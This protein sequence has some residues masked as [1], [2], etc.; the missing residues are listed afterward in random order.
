[1]KR[2]QMNTI[3]QHTL[4]VGGIQVPLDIVVG[5]VCL[6]AKKRLEKANIHGRELDAH[7]FRRSIDARKKDSV[8]FVYSVAVTGFFSKGVIERVTRG[9]FKQIS[10]LKSGEPEVI[11]GDAPLTARPLVVGSGPAGLFCALLLA[12]AGYH[13][14][15]IERGGDVSERQAAIRRFSKEHTLD[16]ESNVQFGAGGAGTFSDGK[17]VTRV[18]D[19]LCQYV[20]KTFCDFGAPKGIMIEAKPHIGTDVLCRIVEN[21]IG[22]IVALGGEVRYH[23]KLESLVWQGDEV[24]GVRTN[25]GDI[26]VGAVV[27]AIGHSARDTYETLLKD[28]LMIEPKP[29]SVGVRV[30]HLQED[31]DRA[32]YGRFAGHPALGAAEYH[33]SHDTK[34]RGVYS[35]CM[36][37]GGY[38]MAAASEP[39]SVVVNGMS[40]HARDGRNANSAIAVSVRCEDYGGT[41]DGAIAFQRKIERAAFQ[42]GGGNY[43]V[44]L[45]TMGDFINGGQG[46]APTR[47]LPTYMDGD[48]FGLSTPQAYLPDFICDA[49]RGGLIAFENKIHGFTTPDALISGAETRTSAPVRILREAESRVAL[50]SKNLYPC[51][52]GAG[53]AGGITSAALDGIHTA[54]AIMRTYRPM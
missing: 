26:P 18:N 43:A 38:V 34:G 35:F 20:L 19:P 6:L 48:H 3:N 25:G 33:L 9:E 30:E 45:T 54:L 14:I 32:L 22:R 46:T 40:Y 1:M 10:L 8:Q 16:T 29:F 47:I 21:M 12:E 24:V 15:L 42:A 7:I 36:C 28:R 53:Y 52:E 23:T 49:L 37:P 5:D 4:I 2:G 17:L 39:D 13:P 31:I 51:G 41:P 27:L 44:P 50:Q 11:L